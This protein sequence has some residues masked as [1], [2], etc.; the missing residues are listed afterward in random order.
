MYKA[1]DRCRASAPPLITPCTAP[2]TTKHPT[3]QGDKSTGSKY[4]FDSTAKKMVMFYSTKQESRNLC[5][6]V[7]GD[8][9]QAQKMMNALYTPLNYCWHHSCMTNDGSV[10]LEKLVQSFWS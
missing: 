9:I 7:I 4:K 5:K 8:K 6:C 1:C 10:F 2:S 3:E